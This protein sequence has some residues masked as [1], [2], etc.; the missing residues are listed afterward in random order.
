MPE[1]SQLND[2]EI[3]LFELFETL[4]R[5]KWFISGFVAISV[6]LG[7]GFLFIT[8][9]NYESKLV[10]LVENAPPFYE[11]EMV[12]SDFKKLF[13]SKSSFEGWKSENA[14]SELVFEEF[15]IT[16]VI[17][18]F[19]YVKEERDLLVNI[20]EE[21]SSSA[22]EEKSSSALVVKTNKPSLLNEF[23]RYTSHINNLLTSEYVKRAE[24]EIKII[25]SRFQS[26]MMS[27]ISFGNDMTNIVRYIV[28]ANKGIKVIS[29]SRPTFPKKISP[30]NKLTLA[31]SVLLGGM[32][33]AMYVL[34]SNSIRK[35]KAV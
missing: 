19:T 4:W 14:Q 29:L 27:D 30:N 24:D 3:D 10:F 35:R 16:E 17:N 28:S 34:V 22:L 11:T 32:I 2:D 9:P 25:D 15:N 1:V 6:L 26:L 33:G 7:G 12:E 8:T 13:Y 20:V 21:K 5:G 31:L 18:G 23:F